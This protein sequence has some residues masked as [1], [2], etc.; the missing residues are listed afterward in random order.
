[1]RRRGA[2]SGPER[3]APA[4]G[5]A[6]FDSRS[7]A[8]SACPRRRPCTPGSP[9]AI[10]S[11]P[12]GT[13]SAFVY[14]VTR[15]S[16]AQRETV[17]QFT[18]PTN[19]GIVALSRGV[20]D[21]LR[22]RCPAGD[23]LSRLGGSGVRILA[24]GRTAGVLLVGWNAD[25]CIGCRRRDTYRG[26]AHC[27]TP[28][29]ACNNRRRADRL[30]VRG[31]K[32]RVV[33]RRGA[34]PCPLL[35]ASGFVRRFRRAWFV[36]VFTSSRACT[37]GD[38]CGVRACRDARVCGAFSRRASFSG[39]RMAVTRDRG[40][41]LP[42]RGMA[43]V[44]AHGLGCPAPDRWLAPR[45]APTGSMRRDYQIHSLSPGGQC[46]RGR[47]R[48]GHPAPQHLDF[49]GRPWHCRPALS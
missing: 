32:C 6:L 41:L 40:Q 12:G 23:H 1:M 15:S 27:Q 7:A 30:R 16:T 26:R 24:L 36:R 31:R 42:A 14:L 37:R 10:D 38:G 47:E 34:V 2:G 29:L 17:A 21:S 20:H 18:V 43:V 3:R 45:P 33:A 4:G 11:A 8:Q 13:A 28:G 39:G 9:S 22:T 48:P 44:T 49:S 25:C 46:L 35:V 5:W 19:P